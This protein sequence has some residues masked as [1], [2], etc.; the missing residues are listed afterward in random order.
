MEIQT[1]QHTD[2][3]LEVWWVYVNGKKALGPYV[4][5]ALAQTKVKKCLIAWNVE[6]VGEKK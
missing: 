6:K 2:C 5:Q 4:S 1:K 3:G